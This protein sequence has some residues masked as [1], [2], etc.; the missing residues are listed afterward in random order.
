MLNQ[1]V[2]VGRLKYIGLDFIELA[3]NKKDNPEEYDIIPVTLSENIVDNVKNY[4][5]LEDVVGIKGN[6]SNK[7]GR[8]IIVANKVTF[9]SSRKGGD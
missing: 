7:D 2:L 6:I 1:I 8:L 9:L 3:V 4:C 5:T